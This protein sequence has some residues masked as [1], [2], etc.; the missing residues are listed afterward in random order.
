M[1][2]KFNEE[3]EKPEFVIKRNPLVPHSWQI[4]QYK[5]GKSEYEPVGDYTLIDTSEA[6]EITDKKMINLAN[7]MSGKQRLVDFTNLTGKRVL[8]N[9]IPETSESNRQKVVFRTYDGTGVSQENAVLTIEK[10][11]FNETSNQSD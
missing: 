11:V 2:L 7:I 1:G 5:E 9:I 6:P 10:G 8:F 4:F 3:S